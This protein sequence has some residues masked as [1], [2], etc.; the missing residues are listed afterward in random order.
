MALLENL[1]KGNVLTGVAIGFG[2]V[3]FAPMAGQVL[4]PTAKALIKGGMLAYKGIADLGE[5]ASDMVAEAQAELAQEYAVATATAEVPAA[6]K[7]RPHTA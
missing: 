3:L 6:P 7:Q 1:F 4:R 2:A 5:V